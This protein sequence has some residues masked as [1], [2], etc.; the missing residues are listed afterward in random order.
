MVDPRVRPL[1]QKISFH[2]LPF[3][4]LFFFMRFVKKR[5][6]SI[7]SNLFMK[8][9]GRLLK[10]VTFSFSIKTGFRPEVW[11]NKIPLQIDSEVNQLHLLPFPCKIWSFVHDNRFF[12]S[13]S[14]T[15]QLRLF[16]EDEEPNFCIFIIMHLICQLCIKTI[17]SSSAQHKISQ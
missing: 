3:I 5:S 16:R 15:D 11:Y 17:I 2:S 8:A 12:I 9:A 10:I 1:D 14:G 6:V 13:I 4:E 7:S